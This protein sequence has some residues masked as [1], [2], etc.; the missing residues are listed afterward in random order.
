MMNGHRRW[1]SCHLVVGLE[2]F[3]LPPC[4]L[5]LFL[6]TNEWSSNQITSWQT[7]CSS[8]FVS[9][10][11]KWI[12]VKWS[13]TNPISL[14]CVCVCVCVSRQKHPFLRSSSSVMVDMTPTQW[15]NVHTSAWLLRI[16]LPSTHAQKRGTQIQKTYGDTYVIYFLIRCSLAFS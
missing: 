8:T 1:I 3:G 11:G 14:F 7:L 9:S 16:V 13:V 4:I 6:A 2:L 12:E 15:K 5:F 10:P